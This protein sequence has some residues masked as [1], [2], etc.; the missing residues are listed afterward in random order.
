MRFNGR[1]GK[2]EVKPTTSAER[3]TQRWMHRNLLRQFKN[4]GNY[5]R[6]LFVPDVYGLCKLYAVMGCLTAAL[7]YPLP[8]SRKLII[9][10]YTEEVKIEPRYRYE[11]NSCVTDVIG[12]ISFINH[13]N[14]TTF[15][16]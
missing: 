15:H 1:D 11:S 2:R 10:R 14:G 16:S 9:R 4:I 8:S 13:A 6:L 7:S 3:A 5:L 12:S